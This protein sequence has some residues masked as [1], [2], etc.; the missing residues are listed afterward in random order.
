[1]FGVLPSW[2]HTELSQGHPILVAAWSYLA[3]GLVGS[4]G[5]LVQQVGAALAGATPGDPIWVLTAAGLSVLG[6]RLLR[7]LVRRN[8]GLP[9]PQRHRPA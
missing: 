5:L 8:E 2:I 3:L 9:A 1:M 7:R 4:A 6:W